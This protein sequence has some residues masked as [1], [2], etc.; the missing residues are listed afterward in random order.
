M[1]FI[2]NKLWKAWSSDFKF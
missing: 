1:Y 2:L